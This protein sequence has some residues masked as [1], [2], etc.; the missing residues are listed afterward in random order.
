MNQRAS[1]VFCLFMITILLTS[2][3]ELK[4]VADGK[5]TFKIAANS[6]SEKELEKV[7]TV[8]FY[9]W[10]LSPGIH[11]INLDD[12]GNEYGL[13]QASY[14]IVEQRIS[15]KSLFFTLVTLGLYCPIDYKVKV[16]TKKES[17]N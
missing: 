1:L 14:V 2:C 8:D 9:F 3:S 7:S 6:T 12:L 5:V 10:G 4:F 17:L 16:L 15:P 11:K 13:D